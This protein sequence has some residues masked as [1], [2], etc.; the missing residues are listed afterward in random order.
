L[1]YIENGECR[2]VSRNLRTL[3]F[4]ALRVALGRLPVKNAII[5]GEIICVDPKGVSQ[6]NWFRF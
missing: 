2:L 4:E 6:F 3:R 5:D 1:A